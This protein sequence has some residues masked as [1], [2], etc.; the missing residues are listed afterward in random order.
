MSDDAKNP[1]NQAIS[2]FK[3]VSIYKVSNSK[4]WYVRVWDS[5]RKKY[6]VKGTGQ[7]S[8]ILARKAAQELAIALLKEKAPVVKEFNFKIYCLKLLRNEKEV[9]DKNQRSV[10]SYKAMKWCI[11]NKDWGLI[12]R[13]GDRDVREITT[14]DFREYMNYLDVKNP[15]WAAST[16]NTILATFRNVLKVAQ[17]ESVIDNIPDTPRS[18]QKDNPRPFFKFYPLVSKDDDQYQMVIK[19][20]ATMV[21][22]GVVS[23]G[24]PVTEELRDILLFITH[25]FV[26]PTHSELYSI[27]HKDVTVAKDPRR[28]ILT[29]VDGKT[30]YR[31]V[32]TMEAAVSVY[33][34]ICERHKDHKPDDYIFLPQYANRVTAG[35]V[36]QRQFK[37]LMEAENLDHD[38]VTHLK[39]SLYSLRHTA[40]CMRILLSG[41]KVNIFNLAKTAGTSVD[42]IERFYARNLP[43]NAEMAKNLQ[44]F[45]DDLKPEIKIQV[46]DK[47]GDWITFK[48]IEKD[49]KKMKAALAAAQKKFKGSRI[50]AIDENMNLLDLINS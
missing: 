22:E 37:D 49:N 12:K 10:G 17:E 24:I 1:N 26:R 46:Q 20:A 40:I 25:S 44:S 8:S 31:V 5:D 3:G 45:T 27:R 21:E 28:L 33:E 18:R 32:N 38:P 29:I 30:G 39:H 35:K 9:V 47:N 14:R 36:I 11:E 15:D 19:R 43:L 23:R 16:K 7:T 42:Q 48:K 34:R 50:R 4:Y 2:I 13:F 41:G 6:I